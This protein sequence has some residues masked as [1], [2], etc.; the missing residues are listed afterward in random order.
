MSTEYLLDGIISTDGKLV[1]NRPD[2]LHSIAIGKVGVG[3]EFECVIR[4]KVAKAKPNLFKYY[5]GPLINIVMESPTFAGWNQREVDTHLRDAVRSETIEIRSTDPRRGMIYYK[6][7]ADLS[8]Y[9]QHEMVEFIRDVK[10]YLLREHG[11]DIPDETHFRM[12]G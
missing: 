11:I 8:K 12:V 3:N 4:K 1:Y 9:S 6:K 7:L 5:W 10:I 2:Y